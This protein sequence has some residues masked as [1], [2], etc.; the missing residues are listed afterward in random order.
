MYLYHPHNKNLPSGK[1]KFRRP[2]YY[3]GGGTFSISFRLAGSITRPAFYKIEK[4]F[5]EYNGV[6]P[7]RI[8]WEASAEERI[9]FRQMM[10]GSTGRRSL[11]GPF[12]LHHNERCREI[13]KETI[14]FKEG[15]HYRTLALS[16]MPNHVHWIVQHLSSKWHMGQLLAQVK[17]F[18]AKK[19]NLLLETTGQPYWQNESWDRV[20][21]SQK[22]L[23]KDIKYT[24]LNPV[25]CYLAKDWKSWPGNYVNPLCEGYAPISKAIKI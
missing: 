5:K 10:T 6:I 2:H 21:R 25:V 12:H 22:E 14:A 8:Y 20:I 18:S 17:S 19:S 9:G 16:I 1:S 7:Q 24:L 3:P 4:L 13:L 11:N 15:E 23:E